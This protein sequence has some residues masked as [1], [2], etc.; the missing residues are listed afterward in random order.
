[1]V[2]GLEMLRSESPPAALEPREALR[3][4]VQSLE[5]GA[6]DPRT[7]DGA[8]VNALEAIAWSLIGILG[9]RVASDAAPRPRNTSSESLSSGIRSVLGIDEPK[10]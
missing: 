7:L 10:P 9:D 1:M 8:K 6:A 4:A 3:R 5:A 2:L